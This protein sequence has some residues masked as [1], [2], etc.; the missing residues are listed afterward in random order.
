MNE[1]YQERS[2][3]GLV[4]LLLIVF[5]I[6]GIVLVMW[7]VG[8][9]GNDAPQEE[10]TEE[11]PKEFAITEEEWKT[12]QSKLH[13]QHSN[14]QQMRAEI[15][16]LKEEVN[17]LKQAKPAVAKPIATSKPAA[18]ATSDKTSNSTSTTTS[19]NANAITMA[20]YS[21]DWVK[22]NASVAFRNNT[23]KTVT[24]FT[25][26]MIYYDMNGNMLD[27]QDFKKS[28]SIDPNMVKSITL[29]G[30]GSRDY[31]AYYTSKLC[32]GHEDR[33]YKVKFELKSY[34]IK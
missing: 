33:K 15:K 4:N 1:E 21:H 23:N 30:Y 25:G 18:T 8:I 3:R 32:H 9:F 10:T 27:Y 24:S 2:G 5:I 26:R 6:G 16:Q 12:L 29:S 17:T 22:S 28:V 31:Y 20:S 14:I 34:T 7:Q 13:Q 11:T 19:S